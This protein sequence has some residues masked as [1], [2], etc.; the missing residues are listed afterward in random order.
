MSQAVSLKKNFAVTLLGNF[1]YGGAQWAMIV[2]IAKLGTPEMMGR[3]VLAMAVT[4]PVVMFSNLSLRAVLATDAQEK[5]AF[6][7]YLALRLLMLSGAVLLIVVMALFS[8]YDRELA[9]VVVLVGLAKAFEAVSDL[10]FGLMQHHEKMSRIS[11]SLVVKGALSLGLFALGLYAT[12]SLLW[13]CVCLLAA[14]MSS[15]LAYDLWNARR[16]FDPG[17]PRPSFLPRWSWPHARALFLTALPLGLAALLDTLVVN[18]PRYFVGGLLGERGL[19]FFAAMAY[20]P[21]VGARVVNALGASA[22]PRLARYYQRG[23]PAHYRNLLLKMLG[24]GLAIGIGGLLVVLVGGKEILTLIYKPEYAERV[25]AFIWIMIAAGIGYVA[26]FFGCGLTAAQ[27]F[28]IQPIVLASASAVLA[29][30]CAVFIPR[31]GITGAAMA[32]A[33]GALAQAVGNAYFAWRA[34]EAITARAKT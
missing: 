33:A 34:L 16:S 11:M 23:E 1:A 30:A 2:V 4:A 24:V 6:G 27:K 29:G 19:G 28:F 13:G 3:F 20:V 14:W 22:V 12:R 32:M 21:I 26:M 8:G 17:V 31:Y 25:G 5:Y 10:F 15:L 7:D 9:W 18:I